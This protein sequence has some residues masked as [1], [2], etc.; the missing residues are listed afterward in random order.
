M[1]NNINE[2]NNNTK[3]KITKKSINKTLTNS[4]INSNNVS[5][6]TINLNINGIGYEKLDKLNNKSIRNIQISDPDKLIFNSIK[7]INFNPNIPE[8]H[9]ICYTNLRSNNCSVYE[10]DNWITMDIKEVVKLLLSSHIYHIKKLV[11]N[12]NNIKLSKYIR[13]IVKF[14]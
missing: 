14:I 2:F 1:T 5:N 6:N 4:N 13:W 12:N 10:D 9:N 3:T 7:E 11:L 8:N